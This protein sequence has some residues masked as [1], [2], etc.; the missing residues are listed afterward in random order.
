MQP[1]RDPK[2][3][4]GCKL[5]LHYCNLGVGMQPP[6]ESEEIRGCKL[7]REV[8]S[9]RGKVGSKPCPLGSKAAEAVVK[10]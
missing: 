3:F 4:R 1:P 10:D 8:A 9:A 2:E 7:K 6:R 5:K